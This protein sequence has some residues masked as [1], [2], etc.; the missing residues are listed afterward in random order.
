MVWYLSTLAVVAYSV[1]RGFLILRAKRG[2]GDFDSS[3]FFLDKALPIC[4]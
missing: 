1:V 3:A 2:Y 4:Y